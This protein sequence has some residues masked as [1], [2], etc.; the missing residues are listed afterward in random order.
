MPDKPVIRRCLIK[1]PQDQPTI[2]QFN[3][4]CKL[5]VV[6]RKPQDVALQK[7][8][9]IYIYQIK[10]VLDVK[11]PTVD[12]IRTPF[13]LM[14]KTNDVWHIFFDLSKNEDNE[15][16]DW[17]LGKPIANALQQSLEED[18]IVTTTKVENLLN[19]IGLWSAPSLV[20]YPINAIIECLAKNDKAGAIKILLEHCND[21]FLKEMTERW[22]GSQIFEKRKTLIQDSLWAH[23]QKKY[24]LA[25]STLVPQ[26]EGII[27]DWLGHHGFVPDSQ[28]KKLEEFS[29]VLQ[30]QIKSSSVSMV[31][32]STLRFIQDLVFGSFKWSDDISVT[33]PRRHVVGHGKYLDDMYTEKNSVVVF[34]LLDTIYCLISIREPTLSQ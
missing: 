29:T 20:L 34:L 23:G 17:P 26:I 6:V 11:P 28:K 22:S 16:T 14:I 19:E 2:V 3:Q 21:K 15:P 25:I 5:F 12:N 13:F 32:S 31:A 24:T 18:I 7:N 33:P 10:E 1:F 27:T 30:Q 8:Q 4:E 9:P